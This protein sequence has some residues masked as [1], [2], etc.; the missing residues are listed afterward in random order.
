MGVDHF[1]SVTIRS[2]VSAANSRRIDTQ[3]TQANA[4]TVLISSVQANTV[5]AGA[6]SLEGRRLGSSW[7][8]LNFPIGASFS[9]VAGMAR[10]AQHIA[11]S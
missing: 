11:V 1:E 10:L 9:T 2:D 8:S 4:W 3:Q 5:R 6:F 7:V